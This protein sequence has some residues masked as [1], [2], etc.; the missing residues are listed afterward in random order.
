MRAMSFLLLRKSGS[1]ALLLALA[2]LPAGCGRGDPPRP[3]PPRVPVTIAAAERRDVPVEIAAFG[4]VSPYATVGIR[5]LVGGQITEVRVKDGQALGRND[6]L[7]AIDCRPSEA[8]LEGAQ[9]ALARDEAQSRNADLEVARAELL[10]KEGAV[11]AETRDAALATADA[12]KATVR[13]DRAA[14]ANARLQI[15]YCTIRAPVAGRAGNVLIN[16]GNVIKANDTGPLVTINQIQPIYV[17]F[18]VPERSLPRIREFQAA[19]ALAITVSVP[20]LAGPPEVGRLESINNQVDATTG[21]VQLRAVFANA[22]E[23]LWPGQF[24]TATLTLTALRGVTVVPTRAIQNSQQG[25]FA[26]VVG[27][28]GAVE[29]RPVTTGLAY[30]DVTVVENGLRPGERVVTDGQLRLVPGSLVEAKSDALAPATPLPTPAALP[31]R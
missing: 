21:M 15:E 13:A 26:F 7:F 18:T 8:V 19:G 1:A 11:T 27:E 14:V 31:R 9:A 2:S 17:D 6:L 12:L 16:Q 22:A 30:G 20:G 5:S 28:S 23:R 10:F 24:V 29:A 25:L 4:N 3:A